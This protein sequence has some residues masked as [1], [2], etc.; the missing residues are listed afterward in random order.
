MQEQQQLWSDQASCDYPQLPSATAYRYGCRCARCRESKQS[1]SFTPYCSEPGCTQLRLKYRKQCALHATPKPVERSAKRNGEREICGG[2]HSWYESQ[3]VASARPDLHEFRRRVCSRC[4][5]PYDG[6][7][8]THHLDSDWALR[9]VQV[10]NCD[11][12]GERLTIDKRG[13]R[14]VQVDHDHACCPRESSCGLC[15]RGLLCHRCNHTIASF[16]HLLSAG[17][18]AA[19]DY[20]GVDLSG[21]TRAHPAARLLDSGIA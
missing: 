6:V 14:N 2:P 3:L 12:C 11:L 16:E 5:K 9:L 4:R 1:P 15:V 18:P 21:D 7:I 17:L 10:E 19:L 13:R 8:R 20:L